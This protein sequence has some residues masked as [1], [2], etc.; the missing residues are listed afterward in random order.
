M[1]KELRAIGSLL[2]SRQADK[3]GDPMGAM[4]RVAAITLDLLGVASQALDQSVV[5]S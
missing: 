2:R 1:K 5:Q 3:P 4:E